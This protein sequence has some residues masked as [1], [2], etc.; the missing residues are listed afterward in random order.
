MSGSAPHDPPFRAEH[1]GSLLR[2]PSLLAARRDHAA[3]TLSAEELREAEDSAIAQVARLQAE[4]G[5]GSIT[6]GEFRREAYSDSFTTAGFQ[7]V[8]V[9]EG[10]GGGW[11]YSDSSGNQDEGRVAM[12]NDRLLWAGPVN[13]ENFKYLASVTP[14]GLP[15]MTLPGPCYL[16]FR[17]GRKNISTQ[18]Y[19]DLD[20]FWEDLV[21]SYH[22]EMAALAEAGCRYIQLDETSIA[23]LGDDAIRQVL[24]ERGDDWEEL[25]ETYTDVIN[26]VAAGTPDGVK[27]GMHPDDPPLSPIQGVARIISS[28]DNYQKMLDLV[29]S[30]SNGIGLCQ[31]NFGLMTDDLPSVIRHFGEQGKIHFVHFR[32]IR[33]TPEK[34]DEAFHDDGK[35]DMAECVRAYRDVG[36]EGVARPDH[37][38]RMTYPGFEDEHEVERLFAIGY[39]KGL[40]EAV[41]SESN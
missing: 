18:A 29:P 27:L 11:S 13:V 31:G 12:V 37:F 6:D 1:I 30:P 40:V 39:M 9:G 35:H 14:T 38:P 2:P 32:D 3:G 5:L 17:A 24:A 20:Q 16:H 10:G 28:V 21:D 23:K 4:L 25:L 41:Y 7:A 34:F 36:Y 33:G 26:R 15:K 22:K 8:G 19:P